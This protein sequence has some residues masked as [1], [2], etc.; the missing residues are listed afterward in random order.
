MIKMAMWPNIHADRL[1]LDEDVNVKLGW[2][3]NPAFPETPKP[4]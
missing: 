2:L 1:D 3:R 4:C